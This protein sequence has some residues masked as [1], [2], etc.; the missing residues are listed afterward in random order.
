MRF[1]LT[2]CVVVLLGV[3]LLLVGWGERV[4]SEYEI[5]I[6]SGLPAKPQ[7]HDPSLKPPRG[8][9]DALLNPSTQ[10]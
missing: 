2:T 7:P 9:I 4:E 6:K 3:L 1:A 8:K 10:V 5:N